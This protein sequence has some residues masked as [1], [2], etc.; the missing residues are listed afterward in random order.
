MGAAF[1]GEQLGRFDGS[2]VLTFAGYN[3]G[4]SRARQWVRRYGDPRGKDIEPWST[5]SSASPIAETRSYVQRVMENYQVYKMRLSG[6]FDI[7]DGSG[8]RAELQP[9]LR[10]RTEA[11]RDSACRPLIV[12]RE[13]PAMTVRHHPLPTEQEHFMD[14]STGFSDFFYASPD[15]LKLTPASMATT[16]RP[17][18][19]SSACPA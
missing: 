11:R 2:Y 3:A 7:V 16:A 6:K 4:P 18:C 9:A 12:T 13:A 19:R 14:I 8:Q 17:D 10:C 15:G 1:L 5:G